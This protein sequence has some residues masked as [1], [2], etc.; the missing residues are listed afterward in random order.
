MLIAAGVIR[1]MA[2]SSRLGGIDG[3]VILFSSRSLDLDISNLDLDLDRSYEHT[4]THTNTPELINTATAQNIRFGKW[5]RL[6]N[7]G[8]GSLVLLREQDHFDY[9]DKEFEGAGEGGGVSLLL[10]N[11]K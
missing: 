10:I 11:K 4:H 1:P 3:I 9:Y 7:A 8:P 6:K 5:G 2:R